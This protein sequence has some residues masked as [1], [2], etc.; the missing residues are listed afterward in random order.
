MNSSPTPRD[1]THRSDDAALQVR[2][3]SKSYGSTQA[4]K[5]VEF[6]LGSGLHVLLGR[7]GAGKSTLF[8]LITGLFVSD[9]GSIAVKGHDLRTQ[10]TTALAHLGVVFQQPSLDLDLSVQA[11]LTFFG[12]LHGLSDEQIRQRSQFQLEKVGLADQGRVRCRSLSGGN[13][14]KVELARALLTEPRL[15]LMDEPT[16]GLDPESRDLILRHVQHLCHT[17]GLSCLWATHLLDEAEQADQVLVLHQGRLLG[18]YTL[19][20]VLQTTQTD[21]LLDAFYQLTGTR[22]AASAP[23]KSL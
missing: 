23:V 11:N 15:L 4:L 22:P 13:R 6:E 17:Q 8:Q 5:Q 1:S 3:V 20:Q 14:R 16:V 21:S 10:L 7:N 18:Q 2:Q 12:R 19:E 9:E